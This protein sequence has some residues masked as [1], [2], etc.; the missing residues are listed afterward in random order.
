MNLIDK[1]L[2]G[3]GSAIGVIIVAIILWLSF[4]NA[5]LRAELSSAQADAATCRMAND[6]FRQQVLEQNAA[7]D[8]LKTEQNARIARAAEA[9]KQASHTAVLYQAD[10]KRLAQSRAK[11]DPCKAANDLIDHYF[12]RVK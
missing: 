10:A 7:I 2:L 4:A 9:E 1:I 8:A 6:A 3:V 11:G 12:A 5:H